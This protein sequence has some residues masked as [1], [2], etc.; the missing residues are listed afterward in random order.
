MMIVHNERVVITANIWEG[1]DHSQ[2]MRGW[3][4][5]PIYE[6]VVIT[7]IYERVVITANIWEGGDHSNIWEG[8][9]HSNIWEGGDHSQYMCK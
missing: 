3:W 2:Y 4:S 6:R 9:D 5:Q 1:G 7:A 8:G